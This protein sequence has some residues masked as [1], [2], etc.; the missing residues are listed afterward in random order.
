MSGREQGGSQQGGDYFVFRDHKDSPLSKLSVGLIDTYKRINDVYY[1]NKNKRQAKPSWSTSGSNNNINMQGSSSVQ[2]SA[3]GNAKR[4]ANEDVA[5][6]SGVESRSSAAKNIKHN[7]GYDDENYDY[8]V[9][10]GD[11]L[12]DRYEIINVLGKG[13]FGQVCV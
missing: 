6:D 8:I 5:H 11:R 13:S 2:S 1:N 3:Q 12:L 4:A 7:R 10:T 9:Q